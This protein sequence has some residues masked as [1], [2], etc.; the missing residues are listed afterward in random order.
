MPFGKRYEAGIWRGEA[1][2]YSGAI[3]VDVETDETS[4]LNIE[5]VEESEDPFTG[6]EAL[7]ELLDT[8]LVEDSTNVDAVSGATYSSDAFLSAVQEALK[9]AKRKTPASD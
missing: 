2:G 7:R 3:V 1:R 9:K 6:G 5:I 4:I 8:V